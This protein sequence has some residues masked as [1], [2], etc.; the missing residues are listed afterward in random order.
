MKGGKYQNQLILV[1]NVISKNIRMVFSSKAS[2]ILIHEYTPIARDLVI[3]K[4]LPPLWKL[5]Q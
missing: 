5:T 4:E 1:A 3:L 2:K